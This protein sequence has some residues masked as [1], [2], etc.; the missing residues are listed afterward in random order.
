MY[1]DELKVDILGLHVS[2]AEHGINS[3]L[4]KLAVAAVDT[5]IIIKLREAWWQRAKRTF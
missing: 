1:L 3:N 5:R 4:G 2:H